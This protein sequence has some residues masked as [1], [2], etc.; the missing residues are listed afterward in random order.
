MSWA[1]LVA[2]P[3]ALSLFGGQGPA[4]WT[5]SM[6]QVEFVEKQI[7][8]PQDAPAP[9]KLYNRY[10]T[11]VTDEGRR[12][13]YA[14]YVSI[15]LLGRNKPSDGIGHIYI[16][17]ENEMPEVSNGGCGVVTFYYNL[18]RDYNP[19]MLC[20]AVGNGGAN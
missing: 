9:M 6:Q 14:E 11:G 20:N 19:S 13:V 16:V 2:V 12:M 8:L 18:E 7:S 1:H 10:Y 3:F 17:K 15:D 5:P 4:D